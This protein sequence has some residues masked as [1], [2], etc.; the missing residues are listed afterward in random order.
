[1]AVEIERKWHKAYIGLGGNIGDTMTIINEAIEKSGTSG[2]GVKE[3]IS[4]AKYERDFLAQYSSREMTDERTME[5]AKKK[6][7]RQLG[8]TGQIT[9]LDD[10][11]KFADEVIETGKK[12][13]GIE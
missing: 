7:V 6:I 1:M 12:Y 10:R 8:K 4:K 3:R 13:A 2:E 9:G 5:K 11:E